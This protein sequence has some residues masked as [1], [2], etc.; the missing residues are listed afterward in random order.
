MGNFEN[1][2]RFLPP[3]SFCRDLNKRA[4][5]A[6]RKNTQNIGEK[7][8]CILL[9]AMGKSKRGKKEMTKRILDN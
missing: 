6:E 8:N 3:Y 9:A 7:L 2:S 4:R 1:P 5:R